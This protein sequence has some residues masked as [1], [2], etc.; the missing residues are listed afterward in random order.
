[1]I[2]GRDIAVLIFCASKNV[3]LHVY[4]FASRV[5]VTCKNNITV[6]LMQGP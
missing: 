2:S 1:M 4:T 5:L 6:V 3:W